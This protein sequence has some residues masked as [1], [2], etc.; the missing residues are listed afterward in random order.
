MELRIPPPLVA[1]TAALLMAGLAWAVPAARVAVPPAAAIACLLAAAGLVL[2]VLGIASFRRAG[3]TVDPH[4][5]HETSALVVRG[6]YR[7]TRNPMYLGVALVLLAWAVWLSNL[8]ALL[9][10]PAF[11]YYMNRYQI[12]P[13]ER[14]LEARFGE[15]YRAYRRRVR[16]W[17]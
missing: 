7:C 14:A 8:L 1:L 2:G 10:L 3:T 4:T 11:V 5:P 15:P 12:G 13:E 9:V 6:V 17:L 16:R